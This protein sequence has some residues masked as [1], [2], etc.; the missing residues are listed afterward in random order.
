MRTSKRLKSRR[1]QGMR[2]AACAAYACMW[3]TAHSRSPTPAACACTCTAAPASAARTL[4]SPGHLA[5]LFGKG[6]GHKATAVAP[7][8]IV[9]PQQ[10]PSYIVAPQPQYIVQQA[11]QYIVAAAPQ[12]PQI[13]YVPVPV[14]GSQVAR[15][16]RRTVRVQTTHAAWLLMQVPVPVPTPAPAKKSSDHP[17][18]FVGQLLAHL[19]EDD[20]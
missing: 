11:P 20:K 17:L 8:Y 2:L 12:Q 10:Q 9:A 19:G 3:L 16:G 6:G 14:S 1:G 18:K 7:Q 15:A 13:Q 5:S 4:Q